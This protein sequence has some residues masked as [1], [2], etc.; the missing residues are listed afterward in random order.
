MAKWIAL[1]ADGTRE[2]M[3][4]THKDEFALWIAVA[5]AF[6]PGVIALAQHWASQEYF[7]HSFL[8]PVVSLAIAHPRLRG[9]GPSQRH[10]GALAGLALALAL[11]AIGAL[12]AEVT[13]TG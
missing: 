12:A 4:P 3:A 11:Y 9:L 6:A 1:R 5:A 7:Q 8:V 10:R 13:L 2:P